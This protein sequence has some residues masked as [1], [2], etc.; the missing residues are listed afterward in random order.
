LVGGAA[1]YPHRRDLYGKRF[2]R[3]SCGAFVGCHPGTDKALGSCAGPETRK[4]RSAAH[5]A[6][7]PI[8]KSGKMKR[9][10]AY[11]ALAGRMGIAPERCHISWMGRS[12]A[13]RAAS[14]AAALAALVGEG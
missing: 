12:E 14:E 11:R 5:A 9:S 8:W 6:F 3:C 4:A 7:D 13:L 2:Y 1:I 10:D